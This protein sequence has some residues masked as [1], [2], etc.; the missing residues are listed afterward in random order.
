MSNPDLHKASNAVVERLMRERAAGQR[1]SWSASLGWGLV[2]LVLLWA[3]Q[4]AEI[5]PLDLLRDSGNMAIYASEFFP[6]DFR[7]W[8]LYLREMAVTLQIALWGTVTAVM[9]AIPLGLLCAEN[10]SPG[11]VRQ[12][13]RRLM[14]ACRAINEMVFAMLFIVAVGLGPFAGVLALFVHTTGTLAKLFSEAVEAVDPRPVD[15]IRATGGGLLI[16]IG[17]GIIPQVMPLWVSY[18]LYRFESN[19]RSASVVGMVGAGG[20]GVVLY[21][22][23]RSF[24]YAQTAALLLVIIVTVTLIDL[25]SAQLRRL[26]T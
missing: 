25:G 24:Q 5:R 26:Y 7:D 17:Y 23:I 1:F 4:G 9:A 10:V 18:T 2:A 21:E 16:E 12:P 6:P 19:V 20:I 14:D 8:R 3:W 11:W 15:G 22:V 13:V